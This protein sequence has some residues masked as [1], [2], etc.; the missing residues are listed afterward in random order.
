VGDWDAEHVKGALTGVGGAVGAFE[1]SGVGGGLYDEVGAF[2]GDE[3]PAVWEFVG[4]VL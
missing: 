3:N 1:A 4:W 2:G